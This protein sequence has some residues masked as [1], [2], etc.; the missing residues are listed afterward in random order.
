MLAK[1]ADVEAD[2]VVGFRG[3]YVW[4]ISQTDGAPVPS[5]ASVAGNPGPYTDRLKALIAG[6]GIK[7]EYSRRIAPALGACAGDTIL[8][9]PD[10]A[11]A[12]HLSTLAHEVGH[13]LLHPRDGREPMSRTVRETEA[14]AVAYVVCQAIGMDSITASADYVTL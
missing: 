9:L 2:D 5:F 4:D 12:E 8:L 11:P 6:K 13:A 3:T 1:R 14:E 7:L 10:L